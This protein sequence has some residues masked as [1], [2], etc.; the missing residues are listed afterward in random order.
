MMLLTKKN[1]NKSLK[2]EK[3]ELVLCCPTNGIERIID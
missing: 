2:R 3:Y 1:Y